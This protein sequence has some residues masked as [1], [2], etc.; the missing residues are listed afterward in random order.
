MKVTGWVLWRE[1]LRGLA[2]F[3]AMIAGIV[4]AVYSAPRFWAEGVCVPKIRPDCQGW[5][6]GFLL[7]VGL[8][9]YG[10]MGCLWAYGTLVTAF[11]RTD[12]DDTPI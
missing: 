7:G 4:V 12:D 5:A 3:L 6:F 2:S 10:F 8:L 1:A 9:G 11:D